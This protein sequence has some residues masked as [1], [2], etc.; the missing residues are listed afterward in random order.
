[1][2][3]KPV[4]IGR[5]RAAAKKPAQVAKRTAAE[6]ATGKL[7]QMP[8]PAAVAPEVE[9]AEADE[10]AKLVELT[11]PLNSRKEVLRK[12]ILARFPNLTPAETAVVSGNDYDVEIGPKGPERKVAG[13]AALCKYL[14]P[15]R[16]FALC[17][18]T[19]GA[20]EEN[21]PVD[22]RARFL[23]RR[24]GRMTGLSC[25]GGGRVGVSA[26]AFS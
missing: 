20:V 7:L 16:F 19:V 18:F 21:V 12:R 1:M 25:P 24:S 8:T 5:Y 14:S 4:D 26:C 3:Q 13:L 15:K 9:R 22:D 2:E 11:A 17:S 10:Y 6:S 23:C